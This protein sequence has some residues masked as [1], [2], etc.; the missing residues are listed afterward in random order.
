ML[1]DLDVIRIA[2]FVK[3]SHEHC[4]DLDRIAQVFSLDFFL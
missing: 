1:S 2:V 3:E 4:L